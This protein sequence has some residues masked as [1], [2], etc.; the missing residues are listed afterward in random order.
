MKIC[1]YCGSAAEND[2]NVCESCGASDFSQ[3][4]DNC[5]E[6][7]AGTVCPVC[8]VRFGAR[9]K[10]CRRCGREYYTAAC[11]DCGQTQTAVQDRTVFGT[12]K[13]LLDDRRIWIL[14][15]IFCPLIAL[16][17]LIAR[18]SRLP[19]WAKVALI[20]LEWSCILMIGFMNDAPDESAAQIVPAAVTVLPD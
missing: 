4:C 9:P 20:V 3:R 14:L 1:N 13:S 5:G 12:G 17:L 10:K 19:T 18:S 7:F 8:G 15:W 11:P 6:T 16:T 2:A